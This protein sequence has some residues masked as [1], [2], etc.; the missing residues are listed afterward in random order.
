LESACPV[1]AE[2]RRFRYHPDRG[3]LSSLLVVSATGVTATTLPEHPSPAWWKQVHKQNKRMKTIH[4]QSRTNIESLVVQGRGEYHPSHR[5]PAAAQGENDDRNEDRSAFAPKTILVPLA[6]S[7][8]SHTALVAA[9]NLARES[10][11]RLVLLHAV[12]LNIAGR[13]AGFRARACSMNYAATRNFSCS[14]WP[15][16]WANR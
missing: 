12:Q 2:N 10:Q 15:N 6:L 16:A 11:A 4:S 1:A 13:S 5:V 8:S 14:N 3:F 9:R 7:G